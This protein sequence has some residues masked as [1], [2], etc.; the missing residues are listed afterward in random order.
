MGFVMAENMYTNWLTK[1]QAADAI[2]VSTKLIEQFAKEKKLQTA[3][4][5]RAETGAWVSVYHPDDVER[6]R[7]ERQP[8]ADPFIVPVAEATPEPETHATNGNAI[9]I[10]Q[11]PAEFLQ[12][13]FAALKAASENSENH[14]VRITERLFL[15]IPE[16]A[17]YSGLPQA[18]L[19]RLMATGTIA[20]MKTGSGWRIRRVDLEKL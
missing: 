8:E 6:L 14:T 15:T 3:K 12:A 4:R 5:Q 7:K 18:H 19:R 2:G 1:A 9:A 16:A 20:G 17:D 13:L 10:R 11:S